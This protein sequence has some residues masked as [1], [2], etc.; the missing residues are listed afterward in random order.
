MTYEDAASVLAA[1]GWYLH[2]VSECHPADR[3]Q[4]MFWKSPRLPP[5]YWEWGATLRRPC[6]QHLQ[7]ESQRSLFARHCSSFNGD[8]LAQMPCHLVRD[9]RFIAAMEMC[10]HA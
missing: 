7:T 6:N 8:M 3:V 9:S 2:S 10:P 5:N 4:L 1:N